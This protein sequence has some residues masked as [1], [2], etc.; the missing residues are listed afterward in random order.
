MFNEHWSPLQILI[1]VFHIKFASWLFFLPPQLN[2]W[3]NLTEYRRNCYNYKLFSLLPCLPEH[4]QPRQI[5]HVTDVE[6]YLPLFCI[7]FSTTSSSYE[8]AHTPPRTH[9]NAKPHIRTWWWC[10]GPQAGSTSLI[11]WSE[12]RNAR[13]SAER[14]EEFRVG[15]GEERNQLIAGRLR[16]LQVGF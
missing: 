5:F 9:T 4:W 14:E 12:C 10:N 13:I 1:Q 3:L 2:K 8:L 11:V 15:V 7:F 16:E 6:N